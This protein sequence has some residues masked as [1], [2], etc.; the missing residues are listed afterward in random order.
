MPEWLKEL[1]AAIGGGTVAL[2]GL[3]TIFRGLL[4]K[5]F[6]TGIES[7]FQKSLEKF[8]NELD[9]STQAYE[10]L[11]E[12]EMRFYEKLEPITAELIPLIHDLSYYLKQH[13]E[14]DHK[15][16]CEEYKQHFERYCELIK[17]LKNETLIH[18]AYIPKD[19][20]WAF[21]QTV[22]QMQD[23]LGDWLNAAKLLFA[24]DYN[25]IDYPMIDN[26]VNALLL[27]LAFSETKVRSRLQSLSG[28]NR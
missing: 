19:V 21:S 14:V 22:K 7:S 17:I 12:R 8:K 15:S 4:I 24:G 27:Q 26:M 23:N 20:F 5:L 11:L 13:N 18:Q 6:E 16:Q 3:L 2:V 9:R 25:K 10:I 28:E 1:I